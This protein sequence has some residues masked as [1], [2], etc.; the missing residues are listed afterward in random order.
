MA[1][2]RTIHIYEAQHDLHFLAGYGY[3]ACLARPVLGPSG[4]KTNTIWRSLSLSPVMDVSWKGQYALN[5]SA[6]VP[7]PGGAIEQQ[8]KWQPCSLGDSYDINEVGLWEKSATGGD[9]AFLNVGNVKYRYPGRPGIHMVV[10]VL[11]DF[12][13]RYDPIY[14]DETA[15]GQGGSA[16]YQPQ[17]SV[18]LWLESSSVDAALIASNP[19]RSYGIIDTTNKPSDN[20]EWWATFKATSGKWT[21]AT[22]APPSPY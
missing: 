18:Q 16:K 1:D 21:I 3:N 15:L 7:Q 22:T 20:W 8:G 12:S 4:V 14:F 11:N 2:R 5:W 10:G 13:G 17:E 9:P 19:S 6:S